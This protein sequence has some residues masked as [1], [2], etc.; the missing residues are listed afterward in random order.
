MDIKKLE[1]QV[2]KYQSRQVEG[3]NNK[4]THKDVIRM[5]HVK[6]VGEGHDNL[7]SYLTKGA[8]STPPIR[9]NQFKLINAVDEIFKTD[10]TKKAV[11]LI[12]DFN[13]THEMIPTE[14]KN[15][16]E[17]WEALLPKMPLTAMI[18]NLNKMTAV[19]ILTGSGTHKATVIKNLTDM[20]YLKA[21]RV[22][23]M[24]VLNAL[25]TYSQG[26]G[27]K[28]S[29]TWKPVQ[30]IVDA[31]DSAFYL[32][33]GNVEPTGKATCLALDVSG[34]MGCQMSGSVLNCREASAAMALIT[35]NVEVDYEVVGFTSS[36]LST[37]K[38]SGYRTEG[39][40]ELRISPKQRLD[41]V[42]R[43]IDS[44]SFGGTD[45]SLPVIWAE[46]TGRKLD[47]FV[48][49]TDNE[50]WAGDI[51]PSQALKKYRRIVPEAKMAVVGMASNGFSI[52]D[53]TDKGMM[54]FVGFDSSAPQ[55]ISSFIKGDF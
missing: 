15:K 6:P 8:D 27:M 33:F 11:Q 55:V 41:D 40:M 21:S 50:T 48:I 23:P 19:G 37:Y 18:R 53:P 39:L 45:C 9:Y 46:Q 43:Y 34:S 24:T 44:L 1:Y 13:L 28:G 4:W 16:A 10:N 14:L 17:V 54:D 47:A 22:H 5:A 35:M 49:Y 42:V 36:R 2:A 31:L 38:P 3:T 26:Q 29:L 30:Q 20:D 25:K 32:S 7:F 51:H 12:S 52:A